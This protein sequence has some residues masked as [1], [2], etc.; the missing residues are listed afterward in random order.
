MITSDNAIAG[1]VT[2]NWAFA[3]RDKLQLLDIFETPIWVFDIDRHCMWWANQAAI[4]FWHAASFDDMIDRDYST[5]S[6][7]VRKRL[8]QIFDHA[9]LGQPTL[10]SWTLYPDD[11][12]VPVNLRYTPVRVGTDHR[13]ALL[14][15]AA[16]SDNAGIDATDQRVVEA[17]RYTSIMISYFT[18]DGDLLSMNPAAREAFSVGLAAGG[19]AEQANAVANVF[20]TKFANPAEGSS[21]LAEVDGGSEPDGEF[22]ML[23]TVGNRWHRLDIKRGRDPVSGLPVIVVVEEDV[24]TTKQALLDLE[25]LNRTLEDKVAVRTTALELARQQAEDANRAKSDFLARMSH[26]LRTPLNAILGFSDILSTETTR[27]LAAERFQE[28]GQHIHGAADS[29]LSLVNDLLDLS[30]IEAGQFPIHPETIALRPL[31]EDTIEIF[32]DS[33]D[34]RKITLEFEP[35]PDVTIVSDKRAVSQ[36]LTNLLSN[37]LKYTEPT[38]RVSLTVA[39]AT[40]ATPARISVADTGRGI[41]P[42]ELAL[43]FE[44]YFRGSADVAR[45]INGTGLGL[46]IC[47]RLAELISADLDIDS[48]VSAGTTVSLSL[49]AEIKARV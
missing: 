44:P 23:T 10:D 29:L 48:R 35:G 11:T 43:V 3:S 37:G 7:T 17:T 18:L 33:F 8:R 47:K 4:R 24:S 20:V 15:E 49:P 27:K 34:A 31:V 32:R 38:G 13:D 1:G 22:L 41:P 45:E 14:M 6:S 39:A 40:S 46:P 28:Y 2:S 19:Y 21:L 26:D 30:R 12:P 16:V 9:P 5:D 42:D 25:Y 36:I